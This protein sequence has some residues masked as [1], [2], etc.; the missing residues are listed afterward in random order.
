MDELK[1]C[2]FPHK[3]KRGPFLDI[4]EE[5]FAIVRGACGDCG[6]CGPFVSLSGTR[7][8]G[9]EKAEA[10][11]LWNT[12]GSGIS[13]VVEALEE[14]RPFIVDISARVAEYPGDRD[15]A[16][17]ALAVLHRIDAALSREGE[18]L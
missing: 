13:E 1:P 2:P 15:E 5:D 17:Q 9:A 4:D 3:V 8:T 7:A 16:D 18:K 10:T 11:R 12:R 14:A 6:A